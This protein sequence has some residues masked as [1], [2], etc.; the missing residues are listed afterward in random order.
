MSRRISIQSDYQMKQP[1]LCGTCERRFIREWR[2]LR[3]PAPEQWPQ[4]PAPRPP[5]A[6]VTA[7]HDWHQHGIRVPGGR[8]VGEKI[9]YFGLS[10]LWRAAVRPWRH[11]RRRR[12]FR[13]PR[14]GAPGAAA[15]LS[16]RRNCLP[17]RLHRRDRDGGNRLP[18]AEYLLRSKSGHGQPGVVYSLLTKGLYFRFVF[19]ENHPPPMRAVS[20][21]G[22]RTGPDLSQRRKRQIMGALRRDDGDH[23]AQGLARRRALLGWRAR[24]PTPEATLGS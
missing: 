22:P 12:D 24:P 5:Q 13:H 6:G 21:I 20:C 14:S 4:L 3:R 7:L 23:D 2:E 19:G 15:A 16:R 18:V 17:G 1:L 11:V 10:V 8:F 9:G